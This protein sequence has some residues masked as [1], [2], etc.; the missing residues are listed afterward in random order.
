MIRYF[1]YG[2][3]MSSARLSAPDRVPS[4]VPVGIATLPGYTLRFHKRSK[5]GSGKCNALFTGNSDDKVIGVIFDLP[6]TQKAAL[7]R[8]E[9]LG[10]GYDEIKVNL[11]LP[12]GTSTEAVAYT[13]NPEWIDDNLRPYDWYRNYVLAG[14]EEHCLPA[15][16][17]ETFVRSVETGSNMKI[18]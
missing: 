2:S 9:G 1:A 3:N 8:A 15:D 18:R 10:S 13:A 7:D 17:I 14:A 16:Y 4:C 5:D 6:L 12:D 11:T